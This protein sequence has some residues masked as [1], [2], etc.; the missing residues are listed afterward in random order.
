MNLRVGRLLDT[1]CPIVFASPDLPV[2]HLS[3]SGRGNLYHIIIPIT[4][5]VIPAKPVPYLIGE[6]ESSVEEWG[7]TGFP[8]VRFF[9]M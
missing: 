9:T 4:L 1:H 2:Q 6:R 3:G 7:T 5:I 8:G